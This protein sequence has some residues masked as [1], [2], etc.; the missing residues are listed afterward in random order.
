MGD[1]SSSFQF[2]APA[3]SSSASRSQSSHA[4][5]ASPCAAGA[6]IHLRP[7]R[8]SSARCGSRAGEVRTAAGARGASAIQ[9]DLEASGPA[10]AGEGGAVGEGE[11]A[12]RVRQDPG[13]LGVGSRWAG[14]TAGGGA[15]R[16]RLE[17]PGPNRVTSSRNFCA[18][19][20]PS[21]LRQP[22]PSEGGTNRGPPLRPPLR[23]RTLRGLNRP[24]GAPAW[25]AV[26]GRCC[27]A[28]QPAET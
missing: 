10:K 16:G 27:S 25:S 9:K 26:C 3:G 24:R 14:R 19:P 2:R 13:S 12:P 5:P 28:P 7:A 20:G 6:V 11:A 15:F 17:H 8:C 21:R 22:R 23:R 1:R 4:S 18:R